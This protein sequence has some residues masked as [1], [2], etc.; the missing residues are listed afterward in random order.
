MTLL[1]VL[2]SSVAVQMAAAGR[3]SMLERAQNALDVEGVAMDG[4]NRLLQSL[5]TSA[6]DTKSV[7]ATNAM[8]FIE[9][10]FDGLDKAG[11]L[12][13]SKC[14][15]PD[16]K[17]ALDD[18]DVNMTLEV[19]LNSEAVGELATKSKVPLEVHVEDVMRAQV[20]P[21]GQSGALEVRFQGLYFMSPADGLSLLKEA[22]AFKDEALA[23]GKCK[24]EC[25]SEAEIQGQIACESCVSYEWYK[26]KKKE[27]FGSGKLARI[28]DKL[29]IE[30]SA[31]S[32]EVE[33]GNRLPS[34]VG[35]RNRQRIVYSMLTARPARV[36]H[37][38]FGHAPADFNAPEMTLD[39]IKS[40]PQ[41]QKMKPTY[42]INEKDGYMA[43]VALEDFHGN[44]ELEEYFKEHNFLAK[45]IEIG[46]ASL[47]G[48]LGTTY[49]Y[50]LDMAE[51]IGQGVSGINFARMVSA[52]APELQE[53]KIYV[54]PA[55]PSKVMKMLGVCEAA[56]KD[57]KKID[58][59]C[60]GEDGR[61]LWRGV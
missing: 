58:T 24:T 36:D 29:P 17:T 6:I 28:F 4:V 35:D 56:L 25:A 48:K 51:S 55:K 22:M 40:T 23:Q 5:R 30:S 21:K 37:V 50:P 59:S 1:W 54:R 15:T 57:E 12:E 44:K 52:A 53:Q 31:L 49:D 38:I 47:I 34:R 7:D 14:G 8:D 32:L 20:L 13:S 33:Q 2:A 46:K 42:E 10:L 3:I 9:T 19:K 11:L 26:N 45:S 18:C 60:S 39:A 27:G 16:P 41:K 61:V 43:A